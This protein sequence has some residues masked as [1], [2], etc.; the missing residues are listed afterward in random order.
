[1]NLLQRLKKKRSFDQN[2]LYAAEILSILLQQSEEN[3]RKIGELEVALYSIIFLWNFF[4]VHRNIYQYIE[5][6]ASLIEY[7]F[8]PFI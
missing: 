8:S 5:R 3:K 2:K 6:L 4:V 7:F 1:M